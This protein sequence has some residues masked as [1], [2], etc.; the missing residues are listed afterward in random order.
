M[1]RDLNYFNNSKLR[2]LSIALILIT[3]LLFLGVNTI[4]VPTV[5]GGS[6]DPPL[7]GTT[8]ETWYVEGNIYRANEWINTSD[9]QINNSAS[10]EWINVTAEIDGNITVNTTGSFILQNCDLI[11]NGN[12]TINGTVTFNNVKLKMNSSFDGQCNIE[13][14]G[15]MLVYDNDNLNTTTV[16]ASVIQNL[17]GINNFMFW[18]RYG[19]TFEMWNSKLSNCGWGGLD[20][21][22]TI[23]T[24]NVH[25]E[26]NSLLY[27]DNGIVIE[28]PSTGNTIVNNEIKYS[29]TG[30][31][32]DSGSN[33]I[34][35]YNHIS[36]C[37]IG[38]TISGSTYNNIT[39]NTVFVTNYG[40][41]L[42]SASNN[43]V[44]DNYVI[45][46][47]EDGIV[48]STATFNTIE[49]NTVSNNVDDG[50]DVDAGSD[51]NRIANNTI[52]LNFYGILATTAD[53][54]FIF[55]NTCVDNTNT[56]IGFYSSATNNEIISNNCTGSDIGMGCYQAGSN[57]F[58]Y[59]DVWSNGVG[60]G[61]LQSTNNQILNNNI[62][63]NNNAGIVAAFLSTG[64]EVHYNNITGSNNYGI[65]VPEP[66]QTVN[67][68]YNW[69]GDWS[70]P[71]HA[72]TNPSGLGDEVS[73]YVTYRPW[74][75]YNMD[76]II[77]TV[78]ELNAT[79]DVFYEKVYSGWDP[80][81][82]P[83]DWQHTDNAPWLKW[84]PTNQTLY[85]KPDNADVG[86]YW[87]RFNLTDNQDGFTIR[88][89]TISVSNTPGLIQTSDITTATEDLYYSNDYES[90]DDGQ[91]TITWTM[92]TNATW[93]GF[94]TDTAILNG[95]PTND[96]VG[97]Y[98]VDIQ[99][100]DGNGGQDSTN[101]TLTVFNSNDAP[102]ITTTD[103]TSTYEDEYYEVIYS[104]TD[105]DPGDALTWTFDT[106]ATWLSWGA[107]NQ[108]L[109]GKPEN[110]DV[111]IYWVKINITDSGGAKD[112]HYFDLTV[113][114]VNDAPVLEGAPTYLELSADD[115]PDLDLEPYVTDIDN[116][117]SSLTGQTSS[118][119]ITVTGLILSFNYDF[120]NPTTE[121]VTI[122][123]TDGDLISN[124]HVII[125]DIII[126][127]AWNVSVVSH[128]PEGTDISIDS[129]ITVTF[130][131]AMNE[132]A[133][134]SAFSITPSI[135]GN[136]TWDSHT[137]TFDPSGQLQY[138]TTYTVKINTDATD[139]SGWPLNQVHTW[140]FTTV[141]NDEI[142][143]DNDGYPDWD[144]AFPQD[145]RYHLDTDGD[146]M[147]DEWED[148]HDLDKNDPN[149][150]Y[151]DPDGDGKSNYDEFIDDTDPRDEVEEDEDEDKEDDNT[152]MMLLVVII[153][154]V[155]IIIVMFLV[156]AKRK[157]P[158]EEPPG[159]MSEP[160]QEPSP[161]PASEQMPYYQEDYYEE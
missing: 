101:F 78:D 46:N 4:F 74:G 83:I 93:L 73:D 56:S 136:F 122:N 41:Y 16:D 91:G 39:Q 90:T 115:H 77:D 128:T 1:I 17:D 98:W 33:N 157:K 37:F 155:I 111:G 92:S 34:L 126:I 45:N 143:A 154:V 118:E 135:E 63:N 145:A 105:I 87:V 28:S 65:F 138:Q 14:F 15:T 158:E 67:A 29:G 150:K 129:K 102:D 124:D 49:L 55:N 57:Y 2:T 113:I 119:H 120:Y 25:I 147:A 146:G 144:D 133:T 99:V 21:G 12:L 48:L 64:N 127:D 123:I 97:S 95:T 94:N 86:S 19:A 79:E 89:F 96:D 110:D 134:E 30:I 137:L 8:G 142:D 76:P 160:M 43:F 40:I 84:G 152:M 132:T 141:I 107:S 108:T 149:D 121:D 60:F 153:I 71:Y 59:N 52:T 27:N 130:N 66:S 23:Q 22:L 159:P 3:S 35:Q 125:I 109:Y 75:L 112:E 68:V 114:N 53:G 140:S 103:L 31:I 47:L 7:N 26:G 11:L 85:G 80:N 58:Q 161:E 50:I 42:V 38:V 69:W 32:I 13:V 81:G 151:L 106:N 10:M 44:F 100:D 54:N 88:N 148:K 70:G 36:N 156:L 51:N 104:A 61:F 139:I 116:P 24:G 131:N 6:G 5:T 62:K 72:S 18:V 9:I 20:R 82:D 117:I